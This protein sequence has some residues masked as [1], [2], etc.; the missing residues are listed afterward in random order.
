MKKRMDK[1]NCLRT[2]EAAEIQMKLKIHHLN[3]F[4]APIIS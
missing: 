4:V 2:Q 3:K 1:N